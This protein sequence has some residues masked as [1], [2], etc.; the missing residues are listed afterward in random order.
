MKIIVLIIFI[1]LPF[2]A[3]NAQL[4]KDLVW[5]EAYNNAF[6]LNIY[7]RRFKFDT[8]QVMV[9]GNLYYELLTSENFTGDDWLGT[10]GFVR[11]QDKLVFFLYEVNES[12]LYDFN[13]GIGD[14]FYTPNGAELEV[15]NVDTIFLVNGEERRRMELRCTQIDSDPIYWIDGIG[16]NMGFDQFSTCQFDWYTTLL[17]AYKENEFIYKNPEVD[18]CWL[19]ITSSSFLK[20]DNIGFFPNPVTD[21]LVISDPEELLKSV[22]IMSLDGKTRYQGSDLQIHTSHF[23]Q[24]IYLAQIKLKHGESFVQ[25]LIKH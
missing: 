13:A 7:S 16:S 2:N 5:T 10:G 23:S 4:L 8:S 9:G 18:T 3:I 14:L 22:S 12:V 17:C 19:Q 21:I 1:S 11:T 6:S 24:G 20:P 25:K 15:I